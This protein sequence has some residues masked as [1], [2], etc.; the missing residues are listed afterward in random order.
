MCRFQV[1]FSGLGV[2]KYFC[3]YPVFYNEKISN[4]TVSTGVCTSFF[5]HIPPSLFPSFL[6]LSFLLPSFLRHIHFHLLSH[7]SF[8]LYFLYHS[9]TPSFLRHIRF[10]LLSYVSYASFLSLSFLI[11]SF[12]RRY[13]L[14]SYVFLLSLSFLHF[15]KVSNVIFILY[16]LLH[17]FRF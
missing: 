10:L 1:S 2:G 15:I 6:S 16:S 17:S 11:P 8:H 9:V 13:L 12:L 14:L 3:N 7:V 5:Y 4:V